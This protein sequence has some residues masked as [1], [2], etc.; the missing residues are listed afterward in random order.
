MC[1]IIE[2]EHRIWRSWSVAAP[3][4]IGIEDEKRSSRV[5]GWAL[6]L[7]SFSWVTDGTCCLFRYVGNENRSLPDHLKNKGVCGWTS[8][9]LEA[10]GR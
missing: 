9:W 10:G 5:W 3:R 2:R 8:F 7:F 1:R 4:G 6:V